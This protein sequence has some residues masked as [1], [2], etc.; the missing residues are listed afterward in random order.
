MKTIKNTSFQGISLV[1]TKPGGT[2]TKYLM[3]KQTIE[4]PSSWGGKI[5]ETLVSR[6]MLKVREIPDEK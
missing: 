2:E 3:P 1:L 5:M 4:V 6:K